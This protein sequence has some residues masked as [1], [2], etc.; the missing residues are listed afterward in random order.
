ME[1]IEREEVVEGVLSAALGMLQGGSRE[2][3]FIGH[4]VIQRQH[5]R[6]DWTGC[7]YTGWGQVFHSLNF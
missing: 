6:A 5:F 2:K 1:V 4:R 7:Q 3:Y